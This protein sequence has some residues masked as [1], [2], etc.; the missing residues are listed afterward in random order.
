MIT[1]ISLPLTINSSYIEIPITY[2]PQSVANSV[3]GIT[4]TSVFKSPDT[5]SLKVMNSDGHNNLLLSCYVDPNE[6][7]LL[8]V[9]FYTNIID[10]D[11]N[12]SG[13]TKNPFIIA[14]STN[15]TIIGDNTGPNFITDT[16]L[17]WI[18]KTYKI[19]PNFD[20]TN[21]NIK[22]TL[23]FGSLVPIYPDD[24]YKFIYYISNVM[25]TENKLISN[26]VN[27]TIPVTITS[28]LDYKSS[29]VVISL[30]NRN[31]NEYITNNITF[32]VGSDKTA[33]LDISPILKNYINTKWDNLS[34]YGKSNLTFSDSNL[35]QFFNSNNDSGIIPLELNINEK[36]NGAIVSG[37][38]SGSSAGVNY[39]ELEFA[40]P[41]NTGSIGISEILIGNY[42]SLLTLPGITASTISTNLKISNI[43]Y[44]TGTIYI[45]KIRLITTA[46]TSVNF[47]GSLQG[48]GVFQVVGNLIIRQS[49]TPVIYNKFSVF[50]GSFTNWD[51]GNRNYYLNNFYNKVLSTFPRGEYKPMIKDSLEIISIIQNPNANLDKILQPDG[52]EFYTDF[53][54]QIS[55]N[56]SGTTDTKAFQL[57]YLYKLSS[58]IVNPLELWSQT[59]VKSDSIKVKEGD[60]GITTRT[61]TS[62]DINLDD[63]SYVKLFWINNLGGWESF[64]FR[65]NKIISDTQKDLLY[66]KSISILSDGN[67]LYNGLTQNSLSLSSGFLTRNVSLWIK[68]LFESGNVYLYEKGIGKHK[69]IPV[70]IKDGNYTSF[71]K[72]TVIREFIF[73]IEYSSISRINL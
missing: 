44:Q 11:Y 70:I 42:V 14:T 3:S 1:N 61:I 71:N 63:S 30:K 59:G 16:Y 39:I 72:S 27:N 15:C 25:L 57:E 49:T 67:T 2:N 50:R 58:D 36:V 24:P 28:N 43:S 62:E 64:F 66:Q 4:T 26:P 8:D 9:W 18:K 51:W 32:N 48:F 55:F 54:N 21:L 22:F 47:T 13:V 33:N 60:C 29:D 69:L 17:T 34:V 38:T 19:I 35:F 6:E 5:Q 73:N 68:E 10:S 46:G 20:E 40:Q 45:T 53:S 23:D 37:V 41:F 31:N 56:L 12:Y 65:K 7:Y 52:L